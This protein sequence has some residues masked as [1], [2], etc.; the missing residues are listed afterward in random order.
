MAVCQ[1]VGDRPRMGVEWERRRVLLAAADIDRAAIAEAFAQK[2]MEGWE[3]VEAESFEQVRFV[4]Q[5]DP[6][7]IL[8]VD[9]S[10]F[11]PEEPGIFPWLAGQQQIPVAFLAG[12]DST[13]L[14][15]ALDSG[16]NHW[17]PRE[18]ALSQPVLFATLLTQAGRKGDLRRTNRQLGEALQD[19][20]R[21][22]HRLVTLL[23]GL[24]PVEQ[25]A[26][27]YTQRHMM[28]RLQEE[29]GRSERYGVPLTVV[30]GEVRTGN[31][32]APKPEAPQVTAWTA[33]R[34]T[35]SKRRTDVAGQYGPG[36]FLLLLSHTPESGALTCC[37]RLQ[38]ELESTAGQTSAPPGPIRAYFGLSSTAAAQST[39]K[40]LLGRAEEALERA[41]RNGESRVVV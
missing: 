19:C 40:S 17:L 6:C 36:G 38:K 33:E 10:L 24:S 4:L 20:R 27:W 8:L 2:A 23:W 34:I 28:D 1:G 18:L 12:T 25:H 37:R 21:Q 7:D 29:L 9:H 26:R 32:G 11:R 39:A 41:S 31:A 5:H 22:V 3:P 13:Q 14:A 35:R 30:V 16:V 15:N